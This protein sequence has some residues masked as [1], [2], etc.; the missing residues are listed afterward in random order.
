MDPLT[1]AIFAVGLWYTIKNGAKVTRAAYRAYNSTPA[2]RSSSRKG[3]K[4]RRWLGRN[5]HAGLG[6][7]GS[8]IGH[9][10]PTVRDGLHQGWTDHTV[11]ATNR[12]AGRAK[13]EQERTTYAQARRQ[14]LA[15]I[16]QAR[17]ERIAQQAAQRPAPTPPGP[18][19]AP[20]APANQPA[21]T[22][23][24]PTHNGNGNGTGDQHMAAP[25]E[26][27][28]NTNC[29][30][31]T[32]SSNGQPA[33]NGGAPTMS[34]AGTVA[35]S[36][37]TYQGTLTACDDVKTRIEASV[38]DAGLAQ[39]EQ[40]ADSLGPMLPG[41]ADTLGAAGDLASAIQALR[42]AATRAM[43]AADNLKSKV[44]EKHGAA[45]EAAQSAG[46]LAEQEFHGVQS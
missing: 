43:E 10:F 29:S 11:A 18:V 28:T 1:L 3:G 44:T 23:P 12:L 35:G 20:P 13:R 25:G 9:G 38:S 27:C 5:G 34:G 32:G 2:R 21:P 22:Q 30:C 41:D 40:L 31:H 45:N 36:D 24:A 19:M 7:W 39:A 15:D 8:E 46:V 33:S 17:Q 26:K 16:A 42:A 4:A 14:H 6:W 37:T